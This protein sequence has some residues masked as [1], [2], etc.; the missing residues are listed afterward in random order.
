MTPTD[1]K[2]Q[3]NALP[4]D[5]EKGFKKTWNDL[6]KKFGP[7]NSQIAIYTLLVLG[8]FF[9]LF[10]PFLGGLLLG[11]IVGFTFSEEI[12]ANAKRIKEALEV[13]EV[14]RGV[15]LGVLCLAFLLVAPAFI[16]G[17]AAAV[18]VKKI[19]NIDD[20]TPND[21]KKD[22]GSSPKSETVIKPDVIVED[23]DKDK[24]NK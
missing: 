21:I 12:L 3:P 9:L 10:M 5:E 16:L 17:A 15:I 18:A 1:P 11:S 22:E 8:L 24:S 14:S 23:K 6:K 2:K 4:P 20:A 13:E 19:V 7:F